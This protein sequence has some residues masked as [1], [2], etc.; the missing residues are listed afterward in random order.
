META[1]HRARDPNAVAAHRRQCSLCSLLHFPPLSVAILIVGACI[2][3]G[4]VPVRCVFALISRH[5]ARR[6]LFGGAN[7]SLAFH[8]DFGQWLHPLGRTLAQQHPYTARA[9]LEFLRCPSGTPARPHGLTEDGLQALY[10]ILLPHGR[11][12]GVRRQQTS[13]VQS[14]GHCSEIFAG[15]GFPPSV[16]LLPVLGFSPSRALAQQKR[17]SARPEG[18]GCP[19]LMRA[20]TTDASKCTR[21]E[22]LHVH[23]CVTLRCCQRPRV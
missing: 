5:Y 13:D 16:R 19:Q 17:R 9:D 4:T 22:K 20:G 21:L 14:G 12:R 23:M 2:A 6:C 18:K 11:R 10:E 8:C 15:V 3:L 7:G 1:S